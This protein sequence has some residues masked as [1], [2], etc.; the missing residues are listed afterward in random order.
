MSTF[1]YWRLG[2]VCTPISPRQCVSSNTAEIKIS[3]SSTMTRLRGFSVVLH[4]SKGQT[5]QQVIDHL[6]LK[7]PAK[8]VIGEERYSHQAGT[9]FH[10]FYRLHHP[11]E[12]KAHL[13][14]WALW[15]KTGRVE[16][17]AM[18]G[19][20]AQCCRYLMADFTKKDKYCDPDPWFYPANTIAISPGEYAVSWMRWF[21]ETGPTPRDYMNHCRLFQQSYGNYIRPLTPGQIISSG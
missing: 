2:I 11:S 1:L 4:D 19:T 9:H 16:C 18:K 3:V 20:M 10:V 7:E 6:M 12:F 8:A 21:M 13:K 17:D 14:H 5:K 15:W